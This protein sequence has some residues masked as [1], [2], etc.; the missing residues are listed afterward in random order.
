MPATATGE[1][2]L[3][4]LRAHGHRRVAEPE[5]AGHD[6][7]GE[8]ICHEDGRPG[9]RAQHGL[10]EGRLGVLLVKPITSTATRPREYGRSPAVSVRP[11]R[12][13]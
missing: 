2:P 10:D 1:A 12:T 7:G 4:A 3:D 11:S 13:A 6:A 9:Q 5:V 8:Q